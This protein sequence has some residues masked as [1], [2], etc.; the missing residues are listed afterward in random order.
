MLE[1]D[2]N[3]YADDDEEQ[4]QDSHSTRRRLSITAG[5]AFGFIYTVNL[6]SCEV[7]VFT[8]FAE[9]SGGIKAVY[10]DFDPSYTFV[11]YDS[12]DQEYIIRQNDGVSSTIS[13]TNTDTVLTSG[14]GWHN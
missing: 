11:G 10:T 1:F 5:S 14:L 6:I 12:N 2:I 3:E 8:G 7:G 4:T 9:L 13:L